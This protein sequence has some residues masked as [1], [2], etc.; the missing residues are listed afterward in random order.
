[1]GLTR[2][3]LADGGIQ[4]SF[5]PT[6]PAADDEADAE[7]D[8]EARDEAGDEPWPFHRP[9]LA[10]PRDLPPSFLAQP[11]TAWPERRRGS[12]SAVLLTGMLLGLGAAVI[13]MLALPL[14]PQPGAAER[15]RPVAEHVPPPARE[16]R[17]DAPA[18]AA[19]TTLPAR[20]AG[21]QAR[22][23][24]A[25][26]GPAAPA[27]AVLAATEP[28]PVAAPRP[29][30]LEEHTM[31]LLRRR[32]AELMA[33]GNVAAARLAYRHAAEAGDAPAAFALAETYDPLVLAR[34]GTRG[35]AP[36]L[37]MARSWYETARRLGSG[38]AAAR[39]GRLASPNW[40]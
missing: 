23:E 15:P 27:T 28:A 32:G 3:R 40:R 7:A 9:R 4:Y 14:R 10:D 21:P 17:P 8:D 19:I 6:E 13:A 29:T 22:L 39:I 5:A 12:R 36:D 11:P 18:P 34:L 2:R 16:P 33:G 25:A 35:I 37:A 20:D 30:P 26:S 38:E 1:M 31:E 24:T